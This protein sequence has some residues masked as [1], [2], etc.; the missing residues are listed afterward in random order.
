MLYNINPDCMVMAVMWS[1]RAIWHWAVE[2]ED[3]R[4]TV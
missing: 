3:V 2:V 4:S 1:M